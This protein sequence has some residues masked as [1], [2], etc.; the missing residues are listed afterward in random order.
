MEQY[1]DLSGRTAIVTGASRG[2]GQYFGRA[3][4]R[5]GADLVT[6]AAFRESRLAFSCIALGKSWC[7][8]SNECDRSESIKL[9]LPH[10]S[11]PELICRKQRHKR[12]FR[13]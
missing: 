9:K 2:L 7:G 3:L 11:P 12:S 1:F 4:A 6:D 13:S 5:A 8:K 10:L